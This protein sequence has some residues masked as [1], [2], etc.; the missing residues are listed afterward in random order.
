MPAPTSANEFIDLVRKSTVLEEKRL[1]GYVE[2][3]RAA[4]ALP[5][6]PSKLA[7]LFVRD[8]V[9]TNFQVEQFLLGKWRRFHIG[10]YKVLERLG[11]G[12]MGSVYLCEHR[13][14]RRR[15]AVKVLPKQKAADT[16]ALERFYREARAVAAL[17]HPNIVRAYDIDQDDQLH[18]LVMEYVDGAS[19]QEIVKKHGR[20]DVVRATHYVRQAAVG[21]QHAHDNG[22]VH[23]D[24]KPGNLL[25]DRSGTVKLLD[26]GLARFFNDEEDN[27]TKRHDENVL[28]TA[29]Y[30]APEQAL[31]SHGVDIRADIYG[32]GATF[33]FMLSG[34]TPFSEGTVAQK[35]IWH[36]TRQPKP[37]RGLRNDVPEGLAAVIEKM[38][39]KD[40]AHRYQVPGELV[41][42]L[43]P[44]TQTAIPP[45]PEEEMPRLSRAAMVSGQAE[46]SLL[47]SSTPTMGPAAPG[48]RRTSPVTPAPAPAARQVAAFRTTPVPP[49]KVNLPSSAPAAS[50][51]VSSGPGS[52]KQPPALGNGKS[53][54]VP[55]PRIEPAAVAPPPLV[56]PAEEE[57]NPP[58]ESLSTDTDDL[59]AQ[60][61]TTPRGS[62]PSS[63]RRPRSPATLALFH[64]RR[65]FLIAAIGGGIVAALF[66]GLLLYFLLRSGNPP[67]S[68]R[69]TEPQ[70]AP[71]EVSAN[72]E[73]KT[74]AA[75]LQRAKTG[76]RI[77]VRS[78]LQE[79]FWV[80]D[81]RYF[82]K[83][84]TIEAAAGQEIVWRFPEGA[85]PKDPLVKLHDVEGLR[86]KGFT[87]DGQDRAGNLITIWGRCPG[88]KLEDLH[89][90]GFTSSGLMVLNCSGESGRPVSFRRVWTTAKVPESTALILEAR[91]SFVPKIDQY[92][93]FSDCRFEGA[94]KAAVRVDGPVAD[95]VFERNRFYKCTAGFVCRGGALQ[96]LQLTLTSNT[97]YDLPGNA[98]QFE[99]QPQAETGHVVLTN[100]LFGKVGEV[101][102][103]DTPPNPGPL[104]QVFGNA[105]GNVRVEGSKDGNVGIP[106]KEVQGSGFIL[107]FDPRKESEFLRYQPASPLSRAG[108]DNAPVGVPPE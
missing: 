25:I 32:L 76:D 38:M 67:L 77:V 18:F 4:G 81:E 48:T 2:Q 72:G 93:S 66:L 54:A 52:G 21:L 71:L 15:V 68:G 8:G 108:I 62:S 7:G 53:A 44:W 99:G 47:I 55:P 82:P 57:E 94:C 12:G 74:L 107:S 1:D 37:I 16:S 86:L 23:R 11:S 13:F 56:E 103:I 87:F 41:E 9:L 34:N 61:D 27:L 79:L 65:Y 70:R 35:L 91:N 24:I 60:A 105:K 58:W 59:T 92:L 26:M 46:P 6:E 17:D 73:I 30:L 43:A 45:P 50:K 95:I 42:A 100:N 10:K 83:D 5:K 80:T 36:Q 78:D 89:L 104:K 14:M 49:S 102:H 97:F 28:G 29:D 20:M 96:Q 40:A 19:L 98:L 69:S 63:R 64:D 88:S 39:A 22:L 31:D 51:P 75:A 101:A 90:R 84:L 33:Y 106:L 3:L 85:D